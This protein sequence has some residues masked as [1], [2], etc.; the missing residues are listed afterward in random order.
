MLADIVDAEP[1]VLNIFEIL[2][3]S[4]MSGTVAITII[5]S[6]HLIRFSGTPGANHVP[7]RRRASILSTETISS[8][9]AAIDT[10]SI[11]QF[12]ATRR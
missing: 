5:S 11:T 6:S 2:E 8:P 9:A 7:M 3:C 10:V 4:L 1:W 12:A